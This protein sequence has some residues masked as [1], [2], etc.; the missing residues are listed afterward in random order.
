MHVDLAE[1][2]APGNINLWTLLAASESILSD[3]DDDCDQD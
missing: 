1:V 3:Q 2:R